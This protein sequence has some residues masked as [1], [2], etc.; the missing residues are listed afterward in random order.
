MRLYNSLILQAIVSFIF[1]AYNSYWTQF[2]CMSAIAITLWN[3]KDCVQ[4]E[5]T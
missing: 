4:F 3:Y 1:H 5:I 2:A